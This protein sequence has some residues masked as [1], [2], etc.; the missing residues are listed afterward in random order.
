MSRRKGPVDGVQKRD[1]RISKLSPSDGT[2]LIGLSMEGMS[3]S[4]L[5]PQHAF[6]RA[7]Q[8]LTPEIIVTP[9]EAK[10]PWSSD[11]RSLKPS[12]RP[13]SSV[14]S[15]HTPFGITILP[16]EIPPMP[17]IPDPSPT[18]PGRRSLRRRSSVSSWATAFSM[19]DEVIGSARRFSSESQRDMFDRSSLN[20]ASAS[21]RRSTGWW[22]TVLS[23]FL[24]RKMTFKTG[25][26]SNQVKETDRDLAR[27]ANGMK[28]AATSPLPEQA[29]RSK[30]SSA[31]S[32]VWDDDRWEAERRTLA[33]FNDESPREEFNR[34]VGLH[35]G[36]M[37]ASPE[38]VAHPRP[39]EA[40]EY[41][42]ACWHDQNSPTSYFE[43]QNH[44]CGP[45][46]QEGLDLGDSSRDGAGAG[47]RG[48][49]GVAAARGLGGSSPKSIE[50]A[51]RAASGSPHLRNAS[52]GT[53]I[54]EEQDAPSLKDS[55]GSPAHRSTS[56]QPTPKLS[57]KAATRGVREPSPAPYPQTPPASV[58]PAVLPPPPPPPI[59]P[60]ASAARAFEPISPEALTPRTHRDVQTHT[61]IPMEAQQPAAPSPAYTRDPLLINEPRA[62]PLPPDQLHREVSPHRGLALAPVD[63]P[64]SSSRSNP[65]STPKSRHNEQRAFVDTTPSRLDGQRGFDDEHKGFVRKQQPVVFDQYFGKKNTR[66]TSIR[67]AAPPTFAPPPRIDTKSKMVF[68]QSFEDNLN[69]K[70]Q[71]KA[72]MLTKLRGLWAKPKTKKEKR[73]RCC[74]WLLFGG[75]L[76]LIILILALVLS[77]TLKRSDIPVQS[78]WLNITGFPPIPT[79]IATIAA[80]VVADANDKC[81]QPATMWS[82]AVPKEQQ[83]SIAPN[84]PDQPNF[85]LQIRY[86]NGSSVTANS[87]T[88][89]KRDAFSDALFTPN[90]SP[91]S[92]DD[93]NF[94]GKTTDNNTAP[95][96][97]EDTPFFISF[98]P[99]AT[100]PSASASKK[101][102]RR[103][104]QR[105]SPTASSSAASA[106]ASQSA[107]PF[108]NITAGIPTP[109]INP[110]GT[111][112]A[113]TLLPMPSSQPLR[114]Y[115]RG[116]PDEHFG[117][118][119]YF[120]RSIFLANDSLLDSLSAG[121]VPGDRDGGPA[122]T[123][124]RA[125]CT[126]TQTRF[127]VQIWTRAGVHLLPRNGTASGSGSNGSGANFNGNSTSSASDF[128][129]PGSFPYPVS[130][131]LDRHGGDPTNK[132]IYCYGMDDRERII[133]QR[134]QIHIEQRNATGQLVNPSGGLFGNTVVA[135]SQGGPGGI[136]GG[137]GGCR[138]QWRNFQ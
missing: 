61:A 78:S 115:N 11:N 24:E 116:R 81:V 68:K 41:Y 132:M 79:G 89:R 129:R 14:Y 67:S 113:A 48:L 60:P 110:D 95:F 45:Y 75:L 104:A 96:A 122:E 136:D 83:A 82:C 87:T 17:P 28:D 46:P 65:F 84:D 85:R 56:P 98:L 33:F 76:G 90:P 9:A 36:Q 74:F 102:R 1:T 92:T 57:P 25:K 62:A 50:E 64:A 43:C 4:H 72:T 21:H 105:S 137:T 101:L 73:R 58:Y 54:D 10:D 37:V 119:A 128:A 124:A 13:T 94:L 93:Q 38:D 118:Y 121:V 63:S 131:T 55:R 7:R 59:Q 138:C 127:L 19:D 120:D 108:P 130:I 8:S 53:E 66:S 135:T 69:E 97:G 123:A 49:G 12:R 26:G 40:A 91:P 71:P 106:T 88:K 70:Q 44:K 51:K 111:A 77:L 100:D 99:T 15:R 31:V 42:Q 34:H 134:R 52:G 117:F 18:T 47:E 133:V 126:W 6:S 2:L 80:P 114:L 16:S 23:P 86:Q 20:L 39:G 103:F 22:N 107:D 27:S 112:A 125:R 5:G 35:R 32:S 3:A 30:R 109:A 29:E